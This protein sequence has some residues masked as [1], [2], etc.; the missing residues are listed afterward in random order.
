M[1]LDDV[2]HAIL[3]ELERNGRATLAHIGVAVGLSSPAVKR[4][5]DQ[6]ENAEVISGYR[7]VVDRTKLGFGLEAFVELTFARATPVDEI[8]G[9]S[10]GIGE[11]TEVVTIA[12]QPDA[13]AYISVRSVEHLKRV[14]DELRSRHGVIGT[15][16]MI[17]L[18]RRGPLTKY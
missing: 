10:D 12:G 18:G 1:P 2:D 14:V 9:V 15:K 8:A 17:I 6:L 13:M 16:T 11:V 3:L 7:A 5:I 4:R